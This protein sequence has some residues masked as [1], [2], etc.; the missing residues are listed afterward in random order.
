MLE[1]KE[2]N[3][4]IIVNFKSTDR[5]NAMITEPVK[6]SLLSYYKTT[7]TKLIFDLHGIKFID[8]SGF[9]VLLMVMKAANNTNGKFKICNI[10]EDVKELFQLLQLH[11]VFE[12]HETLEEC[13]ESFS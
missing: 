13:L 5:F 9:S 2:T 8:S 1:S 11:S 4:I 3:G 12:I 6:E 7:D 10:A